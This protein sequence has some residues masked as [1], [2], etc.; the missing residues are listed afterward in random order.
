MK[1]HGAFGL[2][3]AISLGLSTVAHAGMIQ[4]RDPDKVFTEGDWG[5]LHYAVGRAPFDVL[6]V[7]TTD[8]GDEATLKTYVDSQ[9]AIGIGLVIGID[10][11]RGYVQVAF[12][13]RVDPKSYDDI[14]RTADGEFRMGHWAQGA[15]IVVEA[16][17][18]R[19]VYPPIPPW[20]HHGH[21][22]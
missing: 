22:R 17:G 10:P 18:H 11:S 14:L 1:R 21:C 5:T 16:T 13:K 6:V 9:L 7:M 19:L 3:V 20:R 2:V 12:E 4:V 8:Y 15:A